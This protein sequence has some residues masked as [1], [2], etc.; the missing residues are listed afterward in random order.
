MSHRPRI[1]FSLLVWSAALTLVACQTKTVEVTRIKIMERRVIERIIVTVEVTRLPRATATPRPTPNDIFP[2]DADATPS[3]PV[4]PLSPTATATPTQP[5]PTPAATATPRSSARQ[6]GENL[7][8][9]LR[10]TE[11][12]LLTLVQAL[13]SDPLPGAGIVS[14]YDALR[15][16]P[17]LSIPDNEATLQSIHMRYRQQIDATLGQGTDLYNH[18]ASLQSGQ[19]ARTTVS[20]TH[21]GLAVDA[22]SAGASAVQALIRELEGYLA[23]LP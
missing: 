2:S 23:T 13:N 22:A 14:L 19:V 18:L 6:V 8:A 15:A 3:V 16:K 12:T 9:V 21:L 7:L 17:V 10:D 1:W 4:T 11:Q 5:R 20:P